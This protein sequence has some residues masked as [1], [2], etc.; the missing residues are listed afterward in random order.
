M[1]KEERIE[2]NTTVVHKEKKN[3]L[4]RIII[5]L[6][7]G[8]VVAA[9][10]VGG[11][12]FFRGNLFAH[13]TDVTKVSVENRFGPVA[14][15]STYEYSYTLV[16]TYEDAKRFFDLFNIPFTKKRVVLVAEGKLKIGFDLS[17]VKPDVYEDR[18][19][20]RVNMPAPQVKD[21]YIEIIKCIEDNSIFNPIS[22]DET[23]NELTKEKEEKLQEAK[24][25]GVFDRASEQAR[26]IIKSIYADFVEDGYDL[27]INIERVQ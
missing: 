23:N 9:L 5:K 27:Q 1:A 11:Y 8:L 26:R 7:P 19:I 4:A 13:S 2:E 20:I 17:G 15:L 16:E 25:R 14:E 10:F 3:C 18:K 6:I 12:L 22:V 21:N 24:D